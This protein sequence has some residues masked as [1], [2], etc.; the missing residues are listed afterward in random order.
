MSMVRALGR[1]SIRNNHH[2]LFMTGAASVLRIDSREKLENVLKTVNEQS[3]QPA[4]IAFDFDH[5]AEWKEIIAQVGAHFPSLE[6]L[7]F[8]KQGIFV[9]V[10]DEIALFTSLKSF[11]LHWSDIGFNKFFAHL[12]ASLE[13][14]NLS[15]TKAI[16]NHEVNEFADLLNRLKNLRILDLSETQVHQIPRLLEPNPNLQ[17]LI[18]HHHMFDNPNYFL[19]ECDLENIILNF[20]NLRKLN[21]I[22]CPSID[23]NEPLVKKM[24]EAMAAIDDFELQADEAILHYFQHCRDVHGFERHHDLFQV[25]SKLQDLAGPGATFLLKQ[26]QMSLEEV[27]K[28]HDENIGKFHALTAGWSV[29]FMAEKILSFAEM[30]AL[31]DQYGFQFENLV[32]HNT[33]SLV[34]EMHIP[35]ARLLALQERNPDYLAGMLPFLAR[36]GKTADMLAAEIDMVLEEPEGHITYKE[37]SHPNSNVKSFVLANVNGIELTGLDMVNILKSL[38]AL[39]NLEL[40]THVELRDMPNDIEM[41]K[42]AIEAYYL[43]HP[44][45]RLRVWDD[46]LTRTLADR[47]EGLRFYVGESVSLQTLHALEQADAKRFACLLNEPVRTFMTVLSLDFN[48]LMQLYDEL[49]EGLEKLATAYVHIFVIEGILTLEEAVTLYVTKPDRFDQLLTYESYELIKTYGLSWRDLNQIYARNP[50]DLRQLQRLAGSCHGGL[51]ETTAEIHA[52]RKMMLPEPKQN[53][54]MGF[55]TSLSLPFAKRISIEEQ[56]E[57][58]AQWFYSVI[59]QKIHHQP[60][61]DAQKNVFI[62]SLKEGIRFELIQHAKLGVKGPGPYY[63]SWSDKLISRALEDGQIA[64]DNHRHL[65]MYA[66]VD[67]DGHA[68][69][70]LGDDNGSCWDYINRQQTALP[71]WKM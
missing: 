41:A 40:K 71:E 47:A 39:Q 31:Y 5:Q 2:R 19:D 20:P 28:L 49:A 70:Q 33:Y 65:D 37:L 13:S 51:L 66:F 3:L 9:Q 38:P 68:T 23:I 6:H 43:S 57:L 30:S 48:Q 58:M 4:S 42:A 63:I 12:P 26:L 18:L 27:V 45:F 21:I 64:I 25:S 55:F 24:I 14:L 1:T 8:D 52:Q 10:L 67:K 22:D 11:S 46:T 35:F 60:L 50:D 36:D 16:S 7:S 34:T 44:Q 61:S 32:D 62:A 59:E 54:K 56:A 53:N 17:Q 29:R 15:G 69:Y